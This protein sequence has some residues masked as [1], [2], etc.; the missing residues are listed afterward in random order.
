MTQPNDSI[1]KTLV[2]DLVHAYG[3]QRTVG[4]RLHEAEAEAQVEATANAIII[5]A[6]GGADAPGELMTRQAAVGELKDALRIE[7]NV[8]NKPT[9]HE[10]KE[11]VLDRL[12]VIAGTGEPDL[13]NP[14]ILDEEDAFKQ[15]ER[16]LRLNLAMPVIRKFAL[17]AYRWLGPDSSDM[18]RYAAEQRAGALAGVLVML[19]PDHV[20]LDPIRIAQN[21][22][23]D[24]KSRGLTFSPSDVIKRL[25]EALA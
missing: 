16:E 3:E 4:T 20:E 23:N 2:T 11:V 22:R 17:N 8:D 25:Y 14:Q 18:A 7:W 13:T 10:L 5:V 21:V 6:R 9:Y 12:Q 1:I 24:L 15:R 19:V